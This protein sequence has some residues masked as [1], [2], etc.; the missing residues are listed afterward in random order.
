MFC[1]FSLLWL[2][3]VA[4]LQGC[5]TFT[6]AFARRLFVAT[7]LERQS[8]CVFACVFMYATSSCFSYNFCCYILLAKWFWLSECFSSL[9]WNDFVAFLLHFCCLVYIDSWNRI[10]LIYLS[11]FWA[12]CLRAC[13]SPTRK[14]KVT[15]IRNLNNYEEYVHVAVQFSQ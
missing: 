8:M 12:N 14:A 7:H 1:V 3:H 10:H 13:Q 5:N 2:M 4:L 15:V 6:A 9:I 11:K